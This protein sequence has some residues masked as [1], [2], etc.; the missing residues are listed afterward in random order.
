MVHHFKTQHPNEEVFVS[1]ISPKMVDFVAPQNESERIYIKY[2][3]LRE[4]YL[5]TECIFCEK[6]QR[7]NANYWMLHMTNHLG[8]YSYMC[9]VCDNPCGYARHCNIAA[10]KIDTFDLRKEH[11]IAYRCN[12]CNFVQRR[13]Q[14]I[15]AHLAN[16]HGLYAEGEENFQV[17]TLLPAFRS[18]P[19]QNDPNQQ[20]Q[21]QGELMLEKEN[22]LASFFDLQ[23][24]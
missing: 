23:N 24:K 17:F 12:E 16:Q 8:E 11:L 4:E 18:L 15:R 5:I 13:I 7:F 22:I 1:R 2:V 10:R 20:Q 6:T 3:G 9:E 14:N 19:R 21:I